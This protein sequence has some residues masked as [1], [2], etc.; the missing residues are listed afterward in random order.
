MCRIPFRAG[1]CS[2][3]TRSL[4]QDPAVDHIARRLISDIY[5]RGHVLLELLSVPL[6]KLSVFLLRTSI[7]LAHRRAR[8]RTSLLVSL[9]WSEHGV[10]AVRRGFRNRSVVFPSLPHVSGRGRPQAPRL[11]ISSAS[12]CPDI[13]ESGS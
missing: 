13:V 9:P 10:N 5:S 8:R 4:Q 2:V 6:S 1:S 3:L 7:F 12:S 11:N